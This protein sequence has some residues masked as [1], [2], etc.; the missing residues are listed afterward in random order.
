M[1]PLV[2]FQ[3]PL[4]GLKSGPY[5]YHFKIGNAFFNNFQN[6][7]IEDGDFEVNLDLYKESDM[8]TLV[9]DISGWMK[10]ECDRCLANISLPIQRS[11]QM[12]VKLD[13]GKNAQE[14][15]DLIMIS[16]ESHT[17]DISEL[18]FELIVLSVPLIKVYNC[19]IEDPKPCDQSMLNKLKESN[20]GPSEM[21]KDPTWDIL[22]QIN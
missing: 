20:S 15:L 7:I 13:N 2:E 1:N 17:L 14:D 3:I 12:L 5:K 19:E 11:H 4:K 6:S 16:K 18:V 22:K 8:M 9:F 10:T 21:D